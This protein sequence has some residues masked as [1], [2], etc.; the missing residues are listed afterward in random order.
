[1]KKITI[2]FVCVILLCYP[3]FAELSDALCSFLMTCR[4]NGIITEEAFN[5]TCNYMKTNSEYHVSIAENIQSGIALGYALGYDAAR[6]STIESS[7]KEIGTFV[8]NINTNKFHCPDCRNV[9]DIK[10]K[11][12]RDYTGDRQILIDLG[13][14]PCK[15]CQ[16]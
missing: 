9:R 2:I 7:F 11:N 16:P 5:A 4:Q 12:R 8:V 6:S 3:V 1:M 10:E 14:D 13:F 15:E